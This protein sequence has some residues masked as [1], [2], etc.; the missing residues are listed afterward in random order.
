MKEA[1]ESKALTT[2]PKTFAESIPE[3]KKKSELLKTQNRHLILALESFVNQLNQQPS[4][5]KDRNSHKYIPISTIQTKLDELFGG[6][7]QTKNLKI[8]P[9]ANELVAQLEL[10]ENLV[11]CGAALFMK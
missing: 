2:K 1:E 7:W 8:T 3:I 9:I 10:W 5:V 4:N 11:D 6:L